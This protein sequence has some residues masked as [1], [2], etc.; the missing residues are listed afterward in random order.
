M[1][2][3]IE[4]VLCA[5]FLIRMSSGEDP[6]VVTTSQ[7]RIVGTKLQFAPEDP[8]LRRSVDAYLGVPYAEAPV[9]PLRFK[10]PVAK[11]W[12]GDLQATKLGNRC[13][14]PV[15]PI[16]NITM[17]GPFNEDCLVL[18]IFVPKPVPPKAAVLLFIHG[19][20]YTI[21]AGTMLEIYSTPIAAL[22]DVIV[23]A[24]NYRLGV[25]G[26][27]STGDEVVPGN[28]G[29]LDQR[30]AMEWV[31]DNIA[32][33]GGDPQRVA[34]FGESAGSSSVS[35]H[36]V[37]PGSAGLFRGAIM[38]SGD[39]TSPWA[40]LPSG[41][42]RSRAFALGKLV[43]CEEQTSAELL[44]CLQKV[45]DLDVFVQTQYEKMMETVDIDEM[46]TFQ[47]IADG[48]VIPFTPAE[49]YAE[50]AIND[51]V[52]II[53]SLADEANWSFTEDEARMSK[54]IINYWANLAKTGNPNLSSLDGEQREEEKLPEWPLFTVEELA[55]KDLSPSMENG[56]GIKAKECIMWNEF[57]PQLLKTAEE[58]KKCE[59][60]PTESSSKDSADKEVEQGTCTK[61]NCPED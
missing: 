11:S 6:P 17:T 12:S 15:M 19:G 8:A 54:Q 33:F 22:G 21:G 14:Q 61:E 1:Q 48:D 30:L 44:E 28:M 40:F 13:P 41:K 55:Y 16:G 60:A 5:V 3:V 10:P 31:R 32:A 53:G 50:G 35:L 57:L 47:P 20:G 18:D 25:L 52:S 51:A 29:L 7:G 45:E 49:L 2:V 27:L 24:P 23:V 42:G 34:I 37:S 46:M 56:R 39:A 59:E 58:A 26:F 36:M 4:F 38:Q 43:G 9:G